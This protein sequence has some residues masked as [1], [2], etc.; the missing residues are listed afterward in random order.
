MRKDSTRCVSMHASPGLLE[1][2]GAGER[3]VGGARRALEAQVRRVDG[4]M[5]RALDLGRFDRAAQ[6]ARVQASLL[7]RMM[8]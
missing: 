6:L 2:F 4:E 7:A 1:L 3:A 8:G 5:E